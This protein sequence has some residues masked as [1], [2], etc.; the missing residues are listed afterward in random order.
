MS[1]HENVST[2]EP[3]YKAAGTIGAAVAAVI[4]ILGYGVTVGV[5]TPEQADALTASGNELVAALP[6]LA[7]AVSLVIGLVSGLIASFATAWQ[8]RKSTVPT[9]SDAFAVQRRTP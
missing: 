4:G 7:G 1:D 8:G 9:D 6:Q 2:S 5:L 3:I